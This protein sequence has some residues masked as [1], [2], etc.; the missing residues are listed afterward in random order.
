MHTLR[1]LIS[2][3]AEFRG[4]PFSH[5]PLPLLLFVE[6]PRLLHL[7]LFVS[8]LHAAARHEWIGK[9]HRLQLSNHPLPFAA[10][11][12]EIFFDSVGQNLLRL[13]AVYIVAQSTSTPAQA[14][15][16]TRYEML[17]CTQGDAMIGCQ[18]FTCSFSCAC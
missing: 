5:A 16:H 12:L 1:S 3:A 13:L 15:A 4:P 14:H 8:A 18:I 6:E 7:Q 17:E 9:W 11:S 2:T 10:V